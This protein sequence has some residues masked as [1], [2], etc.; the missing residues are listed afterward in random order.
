MAIN[1]TAD[2]LISTLQLLPLMP[3]VQGLLNPSDLLT[4]L[5]FE[6]MNKIIPIIDNQAEEH[7]IYYFDQP[8]NQNV[9]DYYL[10]YRG[11][12]N[13]LREVC[14]LDATGQ[15]IIIDRLRPEEI[16]SRMDVR[17]QTLAPFKVGFFLVNNRIH[18]YFNTAT[19]I[20]NFSTLRMKY[21][22]QPNTLVLSA[23][24]AQ[25]T[26]INYGTGQITVGALPSGYTTS[27]TYDLIS[28]IPPF[29]SW[30]DDA[31]CSNITGTVM[32]FSNVPANLQIGD[33]VCLSGQ[34]PVPQIP[35]SAHNLLLQFACAKCL[36][37]NG[38]TEGFNVSMSQATAM[39]EYL[40]SILTPRVDGNPIKLSSIDS[41]WDNC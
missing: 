11:I 17:G 18:L 6:L 24:A 26:N 29:I 28:N 39:K 2:T 36:E 19:G 13:R 15:E 34:A 27:V 20:T 4:I 16:A 40:V 23:S 12:G 30:A 7:F 8:Y 14:F 3:S 5:N 9:A 25:I 31:V 32:T 22:R 41:I 38:D 37:I 33:W 10:P 1:Y 35:V 21:I